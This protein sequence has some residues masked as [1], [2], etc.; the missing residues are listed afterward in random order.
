MARNALAKIS[1]L[2]VTAF[3][4]AAFACTS[5]G[6]APKTVEEMTPEE[7]REELRR[8]GRDWGEYPFL[9]AVRDGDVVAVKLYLKAGISPDITDAKRLLYGT[10]H[11]PVLMHAVNV[12]DPEIALALIG[13]G[14]DVNIKGPSGQTPLMTAAMRAEPGLVKALLEAGADPNARI[15]RNMTVLIYGVL[16]GRADLADDVFPGLLMDAIAGLSAE[17]QGVRRGDG[18]PRKGA[19]QG[20][21][22]ILVMLIEAG[23]DVNA[24]TAHGETALMYAAQL[25]LFEKA[26][27]LLAYGADTGLKN[28][29]GDTA[30]M[31]ARKAKHPEM[32][33]L[34]LQ[35]AEGK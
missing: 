19:F 4:A 13:A 1:V 22:E 30:I 11:T 23:A 5:C 28:F 17:A 26:K 6:S 27:V 7:A 24:Q 35:A 18:S 15:G 25:G 31:R 33:Q 20:P 8:R 34:L 14:A 29:N 32:V 9:F 16:G 10:R 3:L 21:P 2:I 12:S